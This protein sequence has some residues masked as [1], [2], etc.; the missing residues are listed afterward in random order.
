[1]GEE[2]AKTAAEK[3]DKS[4]GEAVQRAEPEVRATLD[5]GKSMVQDLAN[6]A[7]EA[8]TQAIGR[9]ASL[10]RALHLRPNRW[11]AISTTRVLSQERTSANM[12]RNTPSP[13]C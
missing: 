12:P 13:H 4:V 3:G 8:S 1:M 10:S 5:Q 6:R 11:R 7:S 2:V 9:R